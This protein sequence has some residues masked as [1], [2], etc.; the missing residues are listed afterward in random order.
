[1]KAAAALKVCA[2]RFGILAAICTLLI[3]QRRRVSAAR[4][5]RRREASGGERRRTTARIDAQDKNSILLFFTRTLLGVVGVV[6]DG[7]E[8]GG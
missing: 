7:I 8:K 5:E 3:G 1:M 2:D 6:G 4:G